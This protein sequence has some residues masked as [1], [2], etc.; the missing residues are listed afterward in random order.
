MH[1]KPLEIA[2]EH[3]RRVNPSMWD[4]TGEPPADFVNHQITYSLSRYTELDVCFKR[5]NDGWRHCCKLRDTPTNTILA[6][7]YGPGINSPQRLVNT[8]VEIS[9]K[10]E[11]T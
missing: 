3:F 4:G 9:K 6:I 7:Q 1:K 2:E 5:D 11:R 8:I 10:L